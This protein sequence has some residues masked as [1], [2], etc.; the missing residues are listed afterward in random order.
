MSKLV[1]VIRSCRIRVGGEVH[2]LRAGN[3]LDDGTD[4]A[5]SVMEQ[6]AGIIVGTQ[7]PTEQ[8]QPVKKKKK[9]KRKAKKK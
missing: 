5:K 7:E 8:K 9:R 2:T 6:G 4:V 1:R 3:T